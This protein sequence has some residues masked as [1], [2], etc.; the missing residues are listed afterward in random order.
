MQYILMYIT[1]GS[2]ITEY[3]D[4]KVSI[5]SALIFLQYLCSDE[6]MMSPIEETDIL[7]NV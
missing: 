1:E 7:F 3:C 2:L 6:M 5:L 4:Y